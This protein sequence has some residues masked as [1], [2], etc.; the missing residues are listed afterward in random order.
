ME[1][2]THTLTKTPRI[3]IS[4]LADYMA[5]SEQR[6]RAIA[7]SCKYRPI[8]RVIQHDEAKTIITGYLLKGNKNPD[9]LLHRATQIRAKL[10]D[11][12]FEE[13][14]NEHNADYLDR[15]AGVVDDLELPEAQLLSAGRSIPLDISNIR[16][17][18]WPNLLLRRLTKTNKVRIGALMLRYSKGKPL[19]QS[20]AE[21]QSSII[22]GCLRMLDAGDG[23]EP[24]NKLCVTVDAQSG[25]IY[26]A[27]GKAT[28]LFN[29]AKAA[30]ASLAEKWPNIKPPKNAVI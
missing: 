13:E 30:C 12:D 9:H 21:Y 10:T 2:K 5:A 18:F 15:F 27:P 16:V 3:S 25:A 28:Y 20:V 6:Q 4:R 17:S 8:A 11:N 1:K 14:T 22:L 19:D 7:Q 26:G 29:E 23:S 24:E